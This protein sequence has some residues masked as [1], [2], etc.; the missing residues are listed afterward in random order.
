[1][2]QAAPY[3]LANGAGVYATVFAT[4]AIG[5]SSTSSIGNGAV[6]P[7]VPGVPSAPT[8]TNLSSTSVAISWVAP[9]DGGSAITD[10][11]VAIR[12]S[13]GVTFTAYAGC[14]GTAVSC[15]ITN[16]VLQAAPYSLA[17]GAVVYATVFAKNAIGI[18]STSS[19]G[20]GAVLP[21]VPSA[22]A[23]PTTVVS[24]TNTIITW[25]APAD[26]GSVIT[27]YIVTI[28]QSDG[29]TFTVYASCTGTAVSCTIANSV[30]QAAP[31]SLAIGASVYAKVLA[32]NA[33]GNSA[34]S[35]ASSA[36]AVLPKTI[37]SSP[38]APTTV[39]SGT[40]VIINLVAPS[41]GGSAIISYTLA[42]GQSDG[43]TFTVYAGCSGTAVSCTVPISV[44]QA[45]PY[46]LANLASVYATVFATNGIGISSTSTS[47]NGAV[48]PKEPS[49]PAAPTTTNISSTSV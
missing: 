33:I 39:V 35:V 37:P 25:V 27:D 46:S 8:T 21:T 44:L 23:A 4:N 13:D 49:V 7:T 24:G 48:L 15:T 22:P 43:T 36:G 18:S 19:T 11:T 30:L 47:G 6:L 38:A 5:I 45:A 41:D 40:N 1:V 29:V 32:T 16:S 9:A 14:T 3:S 42:I 10:Y 28:R 2:L 31:Y 12:Q 17:N 34:Y 26:G 20:N